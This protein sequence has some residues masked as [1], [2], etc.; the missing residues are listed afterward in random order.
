MQPLTARKD[1][2]VT[3]IV[4]SLMDLKPNS[5]TQDYLYYD[6]KVVKGSGTTE[7][8]KNRAPFEQAIV[9]MVGGGNYIE[10]QNLA[11]FAEVGMVVY[12]RG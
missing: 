6:P 10:Y 5:T 3:K 9:F 8:P 7:V 11:D 2:P 4:E 12:D 1:L